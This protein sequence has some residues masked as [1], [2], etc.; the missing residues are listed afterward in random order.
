MLIVGF[1]S[2][3][4][5]SERFGL[6]FG[7]VVVVPLLS[8]YMLFDVKALPLFAASTAVAYGSL[9]VIERRF[10]LFGRTTLLA[11]IAAGAVVPTTFA[12]VSQVA[13]DQAVPLRNVAYL[14]SI[15]P[16]LAAFN[17]HRLDREERLADIIGS[18]TLL[19]G[20]LGLAAF[21][22]LIRS[23]VVEAITFEQVIRTA[24][25]LLTA[26]EGQIV[27]SP[28]PILPRIY[29][30]GLFVLGLFFNEFVQ[31]RY[32]LRIAGV[33]AIPLVA[34]F[35]LYDVRLLV[36]Y[37]IATAVCAG[38]IRLVHRSTFLYGRNLLAG[39][40]MLG[41]F[42][43]VLATPF[44]PADAGLR[45]LMIGILAG[46]SAYNGHVLAPT[47]RVDSI[48]VT[49]GAFA[50]SYLLAHGVAWLLGDPVAGSIE[51]STLVLGVLALAIAC[52][53]LVQYETRRPT[54]SI[55]Q[56]SPEGGIVPDGGARTD[57]RVRSDGGTKSPLAG[58]RSARIGPNAEVVYRSDER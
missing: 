38:F 30:V 48:V 21:F 22:V 46:V 35:T 33:I 5:A 31:K 58:R 52:L 24:E 50:G 16:G 45:S 36:Q 4:F 51:T 26:T 1:I 44:L 39:T 11:A 19:G 57:E 54:D 3:V 7:G 53:A 20:L 6:R 40:C 43:G 13:F 17:L 47:E 25:R 23:L 41:V 29:I 15:L 10:V 56:V 8:M 14:G 49:I 55:N 27:P 34:L 9:L 37:V 2:V 12:L 18:L 28:S 32:G 42:L